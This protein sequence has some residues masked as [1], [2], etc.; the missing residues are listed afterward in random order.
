MSSLQRTIG[1]DAAIHLESSPPCGQLSRIFREIESH[2]DH[3]DDE[4]PALHRNETAQVIQSGVGT[5]FVGDLRAGSHKQ[6]LVEVRLNIPFA[7]SAGEEI[8]LLRY[9]LRCRCPTSGNETRVPGTV[10]VLVGDAGTRRP[11]VHVADVIKQLEPRQQ[12]FAQLMEDG[13]REEA[14]ALQH[15][16]IQE[17]EVVRDLDDRGYAIAHIRRLQRVVE[18]VEENRIS[19]TQAR[20]MLGEALR[21]SDSGDLDFLNSPPGTPPA[22]YRQLSPDLDSAPGTPPAEYWQLPPDF[23]SAPGT[24]TAPYRQSSPH[25]DATPPTLP[26]WQAEPLPPREL[27]RPHE[28]EP[29]LGN[30]PEHLLAKGFDR[31]SLPNEFFCPITHEV[32]TDPVVAQDGHTYERS[33]IARWLDQGQLTSPKTGQRLV[34]K[35]LI[36]NHALRAQIMTA[37]ENAVAGAGVKKRLSDRCVN[38]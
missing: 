30:K 20:L 21:R 38:Q 7:A 18:R 15:Q 29:L 37:D 11:Q 16:V 33:A 32:M 12:E 14:V 26:H 35:M 5:T 36:P 3:E 1:V 31:S 10:T 13:E 9:E 23:D 6:Q 28:P 22:P 4:E 8:E 2:G 34:S 25:F 19:T 17:L 27:K 24:P